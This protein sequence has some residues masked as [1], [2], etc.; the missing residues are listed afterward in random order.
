MAA[1]NSGQCSVRRRD[2]W[3]LKPSFL[4]LQTLKILFSPCRQYPPL[5]CF[6]YSSPGHAKAQSLRRTPPQTKD[7]GTA[8]GLTPGQGGWYRVAHLVLMREIRAHLGSPGFWASEEVLTL[9]LGS[10]RYP[11]ASQLASLGLGLLLGQMH[12]LS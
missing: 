10:V 3:P 5:C 8:D 7:E 6:P 1:S 9:L 2:R 12:V 11:E 4:D